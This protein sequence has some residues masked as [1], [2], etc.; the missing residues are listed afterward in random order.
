LEQKQ[1]EDEE[2]KE[3][4]DSEEKK[5]P[6]A[7]DSKVGFNSKLD[8]FKGGARESQKKNIKENDGSAQ[9]NT[10]KKDQAVNNIQKSYKSE[11]AEVE[12]EENEYLNV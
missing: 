3:G 1:E 7:G 10:S 4:G 12:G 9:I 11:V 8:F 5:E 6:G 2:Q